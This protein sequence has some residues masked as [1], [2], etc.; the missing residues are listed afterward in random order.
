MTPRRQSTPRLLLAALARTVL[1]T[2]GGLLIW[3]TIPVVLGWQPT[4]VM[5]G[6]M[7]PRVL[8]GDVVVTR[9]VPTE[10][11]RPGHVLLVDD[12][13]RSGLLRL[14]RLDDHTERGDLVLRGDANAEVDSTP[15][16]PDAVHGIG[17]LRVPWIG[18]PLVWISNQ[19]WLKLLVTVAALVGLLVLARITP[20]DPADDPDDGRISADD[21]TH[22]DSPE[23]SADHRPG[24]RSGVA[25]A[26]ATGVIF[27]SVSTPAA[28]TFADTTSTTASFSAASTG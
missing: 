3:S 17:V 16:S 10:Q 24:M 14:H 8:I 12:P 13:D 7:E 27:S 6:S 25:L 26:V 20:D 21:G 5:S 22:A 28:A 4:V 23:A 19:E 1:V 18:H 2:L 15:V 9:D 11:L